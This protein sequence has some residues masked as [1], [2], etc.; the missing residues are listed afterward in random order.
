MDL[1]S[2]PFRSKA[3]CPSTLERL[4]TRGAFPQTGFSLKASDSDLA[5]L[6][7]RLQ[8]APVVVEFQDMKLEALVLEL[9]YC[10]F[11]WQ[12]NESKMIKPSSFQVG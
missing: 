6:I 2:N 8:N 10:N 11:H 3:F 4:Y 12:A 9:G 7:S 1:G 5:S